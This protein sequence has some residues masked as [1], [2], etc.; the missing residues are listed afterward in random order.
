MKNNQK[1]KTQQNKEME[2]KE[3]VTQM[4]AKNNNTRKAKQVKK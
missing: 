4:K 2:N 1:H 3:K